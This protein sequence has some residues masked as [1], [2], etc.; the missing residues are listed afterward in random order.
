MFGSLRAAALAAAVW[1]MAA[2]P[3][4]AAT[5]GPVV[6]E[7]FTSQGCSS[8]PPADLYFGELADR[9]GILALAFH[10]DYWN[11]IGWRDPFSAPAWSRRQQAYREALG[12]RFVY[13][14]QM[15]ID[16]TA[17]AV[18]S[19]RG[20]VER[21]LREAGRGPKLDA[22]LSYPGNA[23]VRAAVAARPSYS[24]APA[25]IWIA[26]YDAAHVTEVGA[27]ENRG[28]VLR[29]RNVVRVLSPVGTWRGGAAEASVPLE[30]LGAAGRDAC[31]V[32]VQASGN[33][34]ILGAAAAPLP[35]GGR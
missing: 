15:V 32:L 27:G 18:G 35:A 11:H 7:L 33:G 1:A 30:A 16:G 21:L 25:T 12:G 28:R 24:G 19:R 9:A 10:V 22:R 5:S 13:T 29:D 20:A 23:T 17:Q 8:C 31:A 4:A 3:P 34:A 26:C 6:V 2:A 14:P